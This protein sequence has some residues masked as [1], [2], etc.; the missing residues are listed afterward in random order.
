MENK[1]NQIEINHSEWQNEKNWSGP[2]LI[3]MYFSKADS[4]TWI[5]K[6]N[7]YFGWTLN[8]GKTAGVVW[9]VSIIMAIIVC[10]VLASNIA[11]NL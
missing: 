8:F 9:L 1:M 11:V 4:R 5:R 10:I 7:P 3:S 6:Q 2:K